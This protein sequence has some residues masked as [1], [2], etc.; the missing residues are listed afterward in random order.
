MH[1]GFW[2]ILLIA[3]HRTS[4]KCAPLDVGEPTSACQRERSRDWGQL[5][6]N[7]RVDP[8]AILVPRQ[9]EKRGIFVFLLKLSNSP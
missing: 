6:R 9:R 4:Y 3:N 5:K 2:I 7:G 8:E 1:P